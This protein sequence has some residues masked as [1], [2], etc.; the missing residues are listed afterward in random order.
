M[1]NK[2]GV[3]K[4]RTRGPSMRYVSAVP[5]KKEDEQVSPLALSVG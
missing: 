5:T 1:E 4:Q 3:S 2:Q